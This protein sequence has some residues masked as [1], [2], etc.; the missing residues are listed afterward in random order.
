MNS[1]VYYLFYKCD[2]ENTNVSLIQTYSIKCFLINPS[3]N[4]W[5]KNKVNLI[6]SLIDDNY[7]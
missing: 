2:L 3:K 6:Y 1:C 5:L 7:F 4:M